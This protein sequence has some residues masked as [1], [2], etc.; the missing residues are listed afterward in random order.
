MCV[1][2]FVCV[3]VC[4]GGGGGGMFLW[5]SSIKLWEKHVLRRTVPLVSRVCMTLCVGIPTASAVAEPLLVGTL[6]G[7]DNRPDDLKLL[8]LKQQIIGSVVYTGIGVRETL[9]RDSVNMDMCRPIPYLQHQEILPLLRGSGR[10]WA[11][12]NHLRAVDDLLHSI[13][14]SSISLH[15]QSLSSLSLHLQSLSSVDLHLQSLSSLS[16][17]L[18]SL[19]SVD[20][21]LQSLSSVD[22]HLQSLSSVD[23]HLQSLSFIDLHL[24]SLSSVHLHSQF[25]TSPCC[26]Q[27][28]WKTTTTTKLH[29]QSL[30]FI[31]L[32]S[33]SSLH[34]QSLFPISL[35][36]QS[37]SSIGLHSYQNAC[38]TPTTYTPKA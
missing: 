20:L 5:I 38:T 13:S 17:H 11:D 29:S 35:H 10:F 31:S 15:L 12:R 25:L 22:L 18:Q 6:R 16:L 33:Q 23:L 2:V 34:S 37:L 3:C 36:S 8:G 30:F 19:S 14:L 32:N 4:G 28:W 27:T 21:Y 24:Q 1:C 26:E 7:L 9:E